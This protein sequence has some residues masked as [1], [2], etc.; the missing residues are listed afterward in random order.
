MSMPQKSGGRGDAESLTNGSAAAAIL[1]AGA[2]CATL[3]ILALA[4][5]ASPA[6]KSMLNFYNPTGALSGVTTVAIIV[7]L[8]S[9]FA[10]SR[11]W[12]AKTVDLAKVN[13]AAFA[14]LAIGLMLTF[15]PIMDFIQGK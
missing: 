11:L 7:W 12:A 4:G 1:S 5:D 10:L 14:G 3:G 13:L 6:I 8:A 2:G 15:P 9:W